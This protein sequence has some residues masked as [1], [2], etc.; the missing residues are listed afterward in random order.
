MRLAG[1]AELRA[2]STKQEILAGKMSSECAF[3]VR[4]IGSSLAW[5]E[6]LEDLVLRLLQP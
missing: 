2:C 1:S 3:D 4:R 5:K 6:R